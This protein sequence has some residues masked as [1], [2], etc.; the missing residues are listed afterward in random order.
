MPKR[1]LDHTDLLILNILQ[2][3]GDITNKAL[4]KRL[5]IAP[6]TTL[7]RVLRLKGLELLPSCHYQLNKEALGYREVFLIKL[8]T[9]LSQTD[10]VQLEKHLLA[11][12]RVERL[13]TLKH[14]E[15]IGTT[16]YRLMLRV[17][18]QRSFEDWC[19]ELVVKFPSVIESEQAD[20]LLKDRSSL[21]L[22]YKDLGHLRSLEE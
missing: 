18:N 9:M 8:S 10:V 13:W 5:G 6:P 7:K 3:E 15:A 11:D 2:K 4:S 17:Q 19:K 1:Q 12:H 21:K 14:V 22:T 16:Q 20:I